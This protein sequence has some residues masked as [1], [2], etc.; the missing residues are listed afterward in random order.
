MHMQPEKRFDWPL[1][2]EAENFILEEL[3]TFTARNAFARRLSERMRAETGTLLID[4]VDYLVLPSADPRPLRAVGFVHDARVE[5]PAQ[6][7][8]LWHP[9]AML[10]RV[11]L[12]R[13]A[14]PAGAPVTLAVRCDS[15]ADFMVAH[16]IHHEPEGTPLSRFR[17]VLV[18][19]EDGTRLKAVDRKSVV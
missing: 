8:A 10:P 2:Y 13:D 7:Q 14:P 17:R 1:C 16:G 9:E 6:F 5:T 12:F 3:N 15:I 19:E 11:L 18:S 4:W